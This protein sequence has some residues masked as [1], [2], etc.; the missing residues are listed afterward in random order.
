MT[1]AL[2]LGMAV[3]AG[4][5]AITL[6]VTFYTVIL[7]D[8]A[9]AVVFTGTLHDSRPSIDYGLRHPGRLLPVGKATAPSTLARFMRFAAATGAP[10]PFILP[11]SHGTGSQGC[12]IGAIHRTIDIISGRGRAQPG[13]MSHGY[14]PV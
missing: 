1:T 10:G 5:A 7:V 3:G 6:A 11:S 4:F 13:Y 12:K 14:T 9:R 2:S 8:F